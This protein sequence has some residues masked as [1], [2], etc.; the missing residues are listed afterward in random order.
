MTRQFRYVLLYGGV[1]GLVWAGALG[2]LMKGD[3][4]GAALLGV[5]GLP[6]AVFT[7]LR[8]RHWRIARAQMQ[9]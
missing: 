8:I 7:G 2:S 4:L 1:C 5:T 3:Q 6:F 9:R